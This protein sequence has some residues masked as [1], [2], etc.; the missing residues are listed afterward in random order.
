M[1]RNAPTRTLLPL[2]L[3][4]TCAVTGICQ[5]RRPVAAVPKTPSPAAAYSVRVLYADSPDLAGCAVLRHDTLFSPDPKPQLCQY[6]IY[7]MQTVRLPSLGRYEGPISHVLD[8]LLHQEYAADRKTNSPPSH[9]DRALAGPPTTDNTTK[10]GYAGVHWVSLLVTP[11]HDSL[12]NVSILRTTGDD[13]QAEAQDSSYTFRLRA[14][15][16]A[17]LSDR[18]RDKNSPVVRNRW[19]GKILAAL[20]K[21]LVVRAKAVLGTTCLAS[22]LLIKQVELRKPGLYLRYICAQEDADVTT[23]IPYSLLD[24]V[25]FHLSFP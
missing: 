14:N 25:I 21:R 6:W 24:P 11:R 17:L 12:L 1:K 15:K 23:V 10:M 13:P 3:L 4:L 22:D 8:K 18:I 20:S 9:T 5:P 16:I 19:E 7:E 2:L